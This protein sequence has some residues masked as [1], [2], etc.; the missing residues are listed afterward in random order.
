MVNRLNYVDNKWVISI[1]FWFEH[2]KEGYIVDF[3][4]EG[5]KSFSS[6]ERKFAV[7]PKRRL[8]KEILLWKKYVVRRE[9]VN[10]HGSQ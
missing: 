5:S 4:V 6:A 1:D 2:V 7:G 3:F 10:A 9:G 8:L